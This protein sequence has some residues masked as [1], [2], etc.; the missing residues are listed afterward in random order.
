MPQPHRVKAQKELDLLHGNAKNAQTAKDF[1]YHPNTHSS[2]V[3]RAVLK[4]GKTI[5][6]LHETNSIL[7][8]VGLSQKTQKLNKC[9]AQR[10]VFLAKSIFGPEPKLISSRNASDLLNIHQKILVSLVRNRIIKHISVS[11]AD[12]TVYFDIA[13]L[14]R[15]LRTKAVKDFL[16]QQINLKAPQAPKMRQAL[17]EKIQQNSYTLVK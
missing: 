5:Q 7:A 4:K 11:N 15:E 1:G 10:L 16:M 2:N 3:K 12:R 14:A 6:G 13:T 8:E 9:G 17:I